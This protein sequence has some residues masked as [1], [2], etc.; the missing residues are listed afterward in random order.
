MLIVQGYRRSPLSGKWHHKGVHNWQVFSG[1]GWTRKWSIQ[2]HFDFSSVNHKT[3]YVVKLHW[4]TYT[5]WCI[6]SIPLLSESF[7]AGLPKYVK[8]PYPQLPRS[9]I[10]NCNSSRIRVCSRPITFSPFHVRAL[11]LS[12]PTCSH[13]KSIYPTPSRP[14]FI[15]I[16]LYNL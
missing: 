8:N 15:G 1:D 6:T 4:F 11:S 5:Q 10:I 7:V 14:I 3:S 16:V 13:P 12:H 9:E 2:L